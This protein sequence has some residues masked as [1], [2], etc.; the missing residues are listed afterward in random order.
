MK[1]PPPTPV[2]QRECHLLL[3]DVQAKIPKLCT[4]TAQTN[5]DFLTRRV[6]FECGGDDDKAD[7][8]RVMIQKAEDLRAVC[9]KIRNFVKPGQ[10]SGLQTVLVPVDHHDPKTATVWKTIDDPQQV[11]AVLQARNQKHFRQAEGTPF[12]TREFGKIPFD[13]SGPVADAVLDGTYKS[14]DPVVQLLLDELFRPANNVL[15]RIADL[16][17]AVTDRFKK[18]GKTT[19]VSPF[20]KRYLTQYI[21]LIRIIREPSKHQ[22][23]PP[24]LPPAAQALASIAKELLQLHVSLLQLGIQHKHSYSRWQRVANLMLEKDFGIPKIHRLR[25]I[26]LYE[27]DLNLLMGIYFARVLVRHIES[28]HRFNDGCYGNRAGLSAHEPVFVEELQNTICYLSRT[29]RLDQDNDAT[30][31]YDRIPPNLANLVSGSNDMDQDLCTIHGATLDDM[32]YH[33]L[34]ALG[35]SEEA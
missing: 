11:V 10:S 20:S 28:N 5:H 18:W 33:L 17:S 8:I 1:A 29:N 34:T 30:A 7:R 21:S 6:D 3:K 26:H 23:T 27:A 9:K 32:S 12:T 24:I 13:G 22:D 4:K 14:S 25:I 31:C 15:P 19:S 16:L 2:N 35:I